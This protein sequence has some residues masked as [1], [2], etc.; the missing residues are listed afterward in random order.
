MTKRRP[1]TAEEHAAVCQYA[2]EN[3]RY[4][5][6]R[7]RDDW[8]R[9]RTTGIMQALRNSHGPSW[10]LTYLI[11]KHSKMSRAAPRVVVVTASN[12]DIYEATRTEASEPWTIAYPE[13]QDRFHGNETALRAHVKQLII[14]GSA[15]KIAR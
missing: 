1:L 2:R 7:L 10:L 13:G 8:M 4:W 14:K 9:A 6:A 11:P 15:A 5:K 3:G 12:G